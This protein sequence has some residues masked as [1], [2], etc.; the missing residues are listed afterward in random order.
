MNRHLT[1]EETLD[2]LA[3]GAEPAAWARDHLVACPECR[4]RVEAEQPLTARLAGL[5][6]ETDP[7][8]DM[9]PELRAAVG[10]EPRFAGGHALRA[11]AAVALF[12]LGA[13]TGRALGPAETGREPTTPNEPLAAAAEVQRTGTAYVAALARFRSIAEVTPDPVV[14]QARDVALAAVHGAAWE[15]TRMKRDDPTAREIVSLVGA[16]RRAESSHGPAQ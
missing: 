14:E 12:V 9:W 10:F 11:A 1:D 13:A 16:G 5:P 6:R 15:L 3:P 4:R 2:L 8:R 7:P